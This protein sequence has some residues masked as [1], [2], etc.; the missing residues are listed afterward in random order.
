MKNDS[1]PVPDQ[2]ATPN[3]AGL[4]MLTGL[5][6][7][8]QPYRWVLLLAVLSLLLTAGLNLSLGQ[9]VRLIVDD[10]FVGGSLSKLNTILWSFLSVVILL[11]LGTFARFYLVTWLG[12][13]VTADIRKA[14][15]NHLITLE[16]NYF[17]TNR[18][19]ELMS[20]LTTDTSV[21]Q[22]IIGSSISFALR[23]LLL[24]VGGLFMLLITNAKLTLVVFG[25]LPVIILPVLFF[26]K[27][28]R[29]LSRASQD[30]VADVGTYAG[31]ILQQIKTVQSYTREEN[32]RNAFAKEVEKA[33]FVA[34]QRIMNRG[35]LTAVVIL[36]AFSAIGVMVYVGAKDVLLGNMSGGELAAFIFYAVMVA[37]GIAAVSEV[38]GELQRAAGAT[39][40][41]LELLSV[42]PLIR[43]P[44]SSEVAAC[45]ESNRAVNKLSKH[46]HIE[47]NHV[48]FS[49]PSRPGF[50][51][52]DDINLIIKQGETVALVGSSGAGK[53]TL[54]ELLQRFYD[55]QVGEIQFH[56]MPLQ[57]L[58]LHS[59]RRQMA[60]VPQQPILFSADVMHNIRYGKPDASDEDVIEAAK[61]AY[62]HDFIMQL[63]NQYRSF[64][65]ENGVRLSG[66]QKQRIVIARAILNDPD[67]LLLDEATS[68]LDSESERW[69][70]KALNKLMK[71][72]T[73]LIIAHRL[74]T[75]VH[76][77]RIIVMEAG[78]M[79]AEGSH[80]Q[81]LISSSKYQ[82][83]AALQFGHQDK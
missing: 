40:R 54:F 79:M 67:I 52:L 76:A 72:R 33:F 2:Q 48:S 77:D 12:E 21:L 1:F 3:Q 4:T 58:D 73:T 11:S 16:P 13:R 41:L 53:S 25:A 15:F 38:L 19:G 34:K 8:L 66:G 23:S 75:V 64:L 31:E 39:E 17:E 83:L 78:R 49:Y 60:L 29:A 82:T 30:S 35:L 69:V 24:V 68:A 28:V 36:F 63:P 62:A 61:A 80:Q 81:L 27:R 26:G 5:W 7:F 32:E 57:Q 71:N 10:G 59:A 14:V 50:C 22:S 18:S 44:D 37:G 47:F 9:G 45:P 74:A 42:K 20:R 51:A 56:N 46:S 6:P 55:P 43:S 70:Q 65:G